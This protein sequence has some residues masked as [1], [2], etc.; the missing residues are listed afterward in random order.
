MYKNKPLNPEK[1]KALEL[2]SSTAAWLAKMKGEAEAKEI[3]AVIDK[4]S[5][6]GT[7]CPWI[8]GRRGT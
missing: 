5:A 7:C 4:L 8:Y 3:I 2:M 1:I 6:L